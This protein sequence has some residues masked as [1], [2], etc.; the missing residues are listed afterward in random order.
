MSLTPFSALLSHSFIIVSGIP[1]ALGSPRFSRV[2]L[3]IITAKA[4]S[5]NAND[6]NNTP[7]FLFLPVAIRR[8]EN[9][10][11]DEEHPLVFLF[12]GSSGIGK[13][14]IFHTNTS[15]LISWSDRNKTFGVSL[16]GL[17]KHTHSTWVEKFVNPSEYSWRGDLVWQYSDF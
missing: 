5:T 8:K 4:K 3:R 11:Y 14:L 9:G 12:L 7:L 16:K 17:P 13:S 2:K 6:W 10:W 15:S 1:V